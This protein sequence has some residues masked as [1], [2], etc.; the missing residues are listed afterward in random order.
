MRSYSPDNKQ[1]ASAFNRIHRLPRK[2]LQRQF[3][4]SRYFLRIFIFQT[5]LQQRY[6]AYSAKRKKKKKNIM[7]NIDYFPSRNGVLCWV[8]LYQAGGPR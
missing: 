5:T 3:Y 6:L 8:L 2:D 4:P 7:I 1:T